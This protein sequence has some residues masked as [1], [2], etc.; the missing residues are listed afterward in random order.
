MWHAY[1]NV[2]LSLTSFL[3]PLFFHY[4][5]HCHTILVCDVVQEVVSGGEGS[6]Y[7]TSEEA[8]QLYAYRISQGLVLGT[9]GLIPNSGVNVGVKEIASGMYK[10]VAQ[11]N[12][13]NN[14]QTVTIDVNG[15]FGM[16][17]VYCMQCKYMI[18]VLCSYSPRISCLFEILH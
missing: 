14:S 3:F 17:Y 4:A 1:S 15:E 7:P 5:L 6:S 12:E 2:H 8:G 13:A 11:N 16:D 18:F 10:C 9:R